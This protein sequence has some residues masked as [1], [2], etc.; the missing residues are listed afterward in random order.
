MQAGVVGEVLILTL[1]PWVFGNHWKVLVGTCETSFLSLALPVPL[2]HL[3]LAV[4]LLPLSPSCTR[5]YTR[6][7]GDEGIGGKGISVI[8]WIFFFFSLAPPPSCVPLGLQPCVRMGYALMRQE[9]GESGVWSLLMWRSAS[10]L[11]FCSVCYSCLLKD[12]MP[13]VPEPFWG[14]ARFSGLPA[15]DAHLPALASLSCVIYHS[16]CFPALWTFTCLLVSWKIE[17][18]SL[19]PFIVILGWILGEKGCIFKPEVPF[20]IFV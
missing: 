3:S 9:Y 10:L 18:G 17:F 5:P 16:I 20:F 6:S 14:S 19:F 11:V 15:T 2:L 4:W 12:L 7:W 13:P 1:V 8:H